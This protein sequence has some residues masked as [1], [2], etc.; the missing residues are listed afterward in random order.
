M[1]EGK[2][3]AF[4]SRKLT[5]AQ[6][7]YTTTEKELLSIVETLKEFQ[8]ILLGYEIEIFTD[9]KNLTFE[10]TENAS[11]RAQHW[12]GLI[13]EFDVTLKFIAGSA[14]HVADAI[15]RLPMEEYETPLTEEQIELNLN[16]F[17]CF[18]TV[19]HRDCRPVCY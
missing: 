17:K 5:S 8:N 18:R 3:L 9:H 7:N 15:S 16:E 19:C 10:S 2:P 6:R 12:R 13:L 11:Q 14:N 1:Q 4:F